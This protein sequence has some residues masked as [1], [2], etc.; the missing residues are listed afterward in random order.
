MGASPATLHISR[1]ETENHRHLVADIGWFGIAVPAIGG[2]LSIYAINLGADALALGLLASLPA[3]AMLAGTFLT[4]WW[5]NRYT[6]PVQAMLLPGLGMR[7]RILLLAFIP[8]LPPAWWVPALLA[9]M[10]VMAVATSISN[11]TF[12]VVLQQAVTRQRLTSLVS[13]RQFVMN[14]CIAGSTLLLGVWLERVAFPVNYQV[15]FGV[16]F[17]ATMVSL[18][19]VQRIRP[20]PEEADTPP[21][22]TMRGPG[23]QTSARPWRIPAFRSTAFL[24]GLVFLCYF[25]ILP[26]IPL[27]LVNNLGA[28]EGFISIYSFLELMGAATMARFASQLVSRFGH[29]TMV[30]TG[31]TITGVSA[32]ILSV[33]PTLI[34]TLPAALINGAAWTATDI[35]QFSYFN[36]TV[37]QAR[38]TPFTNAYFQALAVAMFIG[39]MIGS[40]LASSG[41]AIPV[42]L[43]IGAGLR[44]LSGWLMHRHRVEPP[45]LA[46]VAASA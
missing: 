46:N 20:L 43:L 8:F 3:I 37:A 25:S 13:R 17:A 18:W 1:Q 6:D 35:S 33:A 24:I 19:H 41:I 40:T 5:S 31:M 29:R 44:I 26:V 38:K 14:L 23:P 45:A 32:I 11:V 2:F 22:E 36:Q 28:S 39:P 16:L 15:M 27:R 12:L 34:I 30:L 21:A 9:A 42:V 4:E 7:L 10:T